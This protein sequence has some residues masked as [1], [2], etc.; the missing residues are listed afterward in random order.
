MVVSHGGGKTIAARV[1]GSLGKTVA[2][3]LQK[4]KINKTK[5]NSIRDSNE[6][7]VVGCHYFVEEYMKRI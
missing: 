4:Q 5:H 2:L 7:N 1:G 6:T 3:A